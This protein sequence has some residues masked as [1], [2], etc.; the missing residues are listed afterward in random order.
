[1]AEQPS[2]SRQVQATN[3]S[4]NE[5]DE[6]QQDSRTDTC[7][8]D[9]GKEPVHQHSVHSEAADGQVDEA[10]VM[11]YLDRHM[12]HKALQ[13]A[14]QDETIYGGDMTLVGVHGDTYACNMRSF[15]RGETER[16]AGQERDL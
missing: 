3:S 15:E 1:M 12:C 7:P 5:R 9:D 16:V 11:A 6:Q 13:S 4:R 2:S 14:D 8:L 10:Y